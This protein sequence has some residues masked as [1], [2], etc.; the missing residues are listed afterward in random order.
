MVKDAKE[1]FAICDIWSC[2]FWNRIF[3]DT[4]TEIS[5]HAHVEN[6]DD[7]MFHFF[8]IGNKLRR[9]VLQKSAKSA[10]QKTKPLKYKIYI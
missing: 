10:V 1:K 9:D 5:T 8:H 2:Q 3:T 4:K 6:K 7:V